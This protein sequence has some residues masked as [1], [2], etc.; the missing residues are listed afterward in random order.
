MA[1]AKKTRAQKEARNQKV[2]SLV[3]KFEQIAV[4]LVKVWFTVNGVPT[5]YIVAAEDVDKLAK[6]VL[7][8]EQ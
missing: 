7:G 3:R 6:E 8:D 4:G 2:K 5:K 1:K